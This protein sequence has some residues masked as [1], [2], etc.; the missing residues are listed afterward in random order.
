MNTRLLSIVSKTGDWQY[1]D[2]MAWIT[3]TTASSMLDENEQWCM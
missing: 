1:L 3:N 2:L